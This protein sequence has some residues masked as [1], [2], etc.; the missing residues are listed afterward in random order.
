MDEAVEGLEE[1]FIEDMWDGL[2]EE[3]II[4]GVFDGSNLFVGLSEGT[5]VGT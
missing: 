1:G 2:R 5:W 4:E 3:S